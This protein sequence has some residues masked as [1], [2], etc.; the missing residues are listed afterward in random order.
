MAMSLVARSTRN[1]STGRIVASGPRRHLVLERAVGT[2]DGLYLRLRL[3]S[4]RYNS[5]PT[6][7]CQPRRVSPASERHLMGPEI[8]TIIIAA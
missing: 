7:C 4:A 8:L 3:C 1:R 6:F 5:V 2:A